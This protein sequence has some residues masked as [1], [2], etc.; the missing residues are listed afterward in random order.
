LRPGETLCYFPAR[1]A[2]GPRRQG[3]DTMDLGLKGR[4][5]IVTGGSRGIGRAT[6]EILAA[7]GCSVGFFS[8]HADQVA[9]TRKALESKGVKAVGAELDM[10]NADAYTKWLRDT[11]EALGGCDIFIH[12]ASASG[13]PNGT[14]DWQKNLDIDMLGAVRGCETLLPWLEKSTAPAIVLLSSTAATETF[15]MPQAFNAIKAGLITYGKQLS[16][17]W[18][19][20]KIRV[21]M[22][23]PGPTLHPGG[24]WEFIQNR[25]K[26]LYDST[27][28]QI[29]FGRLGTAEEI[30]RAVVFLASPAASYITGVNLVVDGGFTKRVQY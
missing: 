27:V 15:I 1:F 7:E 30:A 13:S 24:N 18:G 16:Q 12:N 20:K 8:R 2:G 5:A 21:N 6:S 10:S 26:A 11:A 22:V 25:M 14:A 28:A 9:E 4:K 23:S 19:E 17:F 29:P 3:S